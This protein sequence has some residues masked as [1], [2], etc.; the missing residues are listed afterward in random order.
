M[1]ED[2]YLVPGSEGVTPAI[3]LPDA[4]GDFTETTQD[5]VGLQPRKID[6]INPFQPLTPA[7]ELETRRKLNYEQ[8]HLDTIAGASGA[9][10][11]KLLADQPKRDE[12]GAAPTGPYSVPG[13]EGVVPAIA[14]DEFKFSPGGLSGHSKGR[15]CKYQGGDSRL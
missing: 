11:N 7:Q 4:P 5:K 1:A 6:K 3:T 12:A 8:S 10:L 2:P 9:L 13:S 15:A 14:L